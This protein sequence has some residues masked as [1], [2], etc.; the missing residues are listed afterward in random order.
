M[1]ISNSENIL[2]YPVAFLNC[3]FSTG[4]FPCYTLLF[5]IN[6]CFPTGNMLCYTLLFSINICFPTG[7]SPCYTLLHSQNIYFPTVKSPKQAKTKSKE[8]SP[9]LIKKTSQKN[10]PH[11][12]P[13]PQKNRFPGT[14]SKSLAV[15]RLFTSYFETAATHKLSAD[16]VSWKH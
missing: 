12:T 6:I 16:G 5:S 2:I 7:K 13:L 14:K 9:W 4:K 15:A 11:G 1:F 3:F 8:P 10:R